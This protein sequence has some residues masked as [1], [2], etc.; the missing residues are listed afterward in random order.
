MNVF[1]HF[2]TSDAVG[3]IRREGLTLGLT[4]T[5]DG[6]FVTRTQWLTKD[7]DVGHQQVL[8]GVTG[9]WDRTDARVKL[10]IPTPCMERL[11]PFAAFCR[12]FPELYGKRILPELTLCPE[13]SWFVYL[14]VIPASWIINI[15]HY[16]P[17][18][19][20]AAR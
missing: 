13:E 3:P 5:G 15:R 9:L 19:K 4:P 18:G 1:Y 17:S 7:G 10:C 8:K 14:G 16:H 2:T 11:R 6:G 12:E 20:G